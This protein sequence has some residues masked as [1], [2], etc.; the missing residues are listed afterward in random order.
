MDG[1]DVNLGHIDLDYGRQ[2]G[3][4][5]NELIKFAPLF[6][7][8]TDSERELLAAGF[9]EGQ[10]P[11]QTVLLTAGERSEAMYLIGQ[12]FVSLTTTHGT[13]LATLGPGSLI[14]DA[15]L[16]R[17]APQDVN[18]V[19]LSEISYWK[20]TDGRL[21]EL[22]LQQPTLGLKLGRNFGGLLAQMQEYLAR[23]LA[24]VPELATVPAHTLRADGRAARPARA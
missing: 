16:F 1:D 11:A 20:L 12:G 19:A 6:A 9:A 10:S 18:A 8:L 2:G 5:K 15:S 4:V 17:N 13:N 21:R 7:G 14:G 3:F 24:D 22:I 23:R